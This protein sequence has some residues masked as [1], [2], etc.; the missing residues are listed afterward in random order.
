MLTFQSIE[1][2]SKS[3]LYQIYV[4]LLKKIEEKDGF[5]NK[6]V[7]QCSAYIK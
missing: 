6:Y 1:K 3:E 2:L 4:D 7:L 5:K